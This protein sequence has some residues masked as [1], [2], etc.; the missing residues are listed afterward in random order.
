MIYIPSQDPALPPTCER[1]GKHPASNQENLLRIW[2]AGS[3]EESDAR[4]FL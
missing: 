2:I 3:F 1:L 4:A